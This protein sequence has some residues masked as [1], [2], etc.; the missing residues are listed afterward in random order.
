MVVVTMFCITLV[1]V[2]NCE[3][4]KKKVVFLAAGIGLCLVFT[5]WFPGLVRVKAG[6][7]KPYVSFE[8][9]GGKRYYRTRKRFR[10]WMKK[11]LEEEGIVIYG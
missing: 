4:V 8:W 6:K 1:V 7:E 3:G 9:D 2:R 10:K 5:F 11:K